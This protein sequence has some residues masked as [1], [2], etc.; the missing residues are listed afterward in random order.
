MKHIPKLPKYFNKTSLFNSVIL[1]TRN[2]YGKGFFFLIYAVIGLKK[3]KKKR[4][5]YILKKF[6]YG[7]IYATM[8]RSE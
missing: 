8:G 6:L 7:T 2:Y 5:F 3:C 1:T 4:F